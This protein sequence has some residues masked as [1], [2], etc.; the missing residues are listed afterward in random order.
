MGLRTRLPVARTGIALWLPTLVAVAGVLLTLALWQI[1]IAHRQAALTERFQI[2]AE[3][4]ANAIDRE[5]SANLSVVA[6]LAGVVGENDRLD[7]AAFLGVSRAALETRT[8]PIQ[9]LEWIPAVAH[10]DRAAFEQQMGF[11][12]RERNAGGELV[13]AAERDLYFP[14]SLVN[15]FV[16]NEAAVGFDLGSS[17]ARLESL[18]RARDTGEL[19][20][21]HPIRLVQGTGEQF[22]F[23]AVNPVFGSA[24]E[25]GI[26]E[27]RREHLLGFTLGVYHATDL[28]GGALSVFDTEE[29][30]IVLVD[31]NAPTTEQVFA[32]HPASL[33]LTTE[34]DLTVS[35]PEFRQEHVV[36]VGASQWTIVVQAA[37]AFRAL[38]AVDRW[39]VLVGGLI[40]TAL[41]V[42]LLRTTLVRA[43]Q[44]RE[45]VV[46]RTE[47]LRVQR[48]R[49]QS[50][51][52]NAQVGIFTT[53]PDN[54]TRTI[55]AAGLRLLD[56]PFE[57]LLEKTPLDL[58]APTHHH[59]MADRR[60]R[61]DAGETVEPMVEIPLLVGGDGDSRW[62]S[63]H[64]QPMF[65]ANRKFEGTQGIFSDISE[66]I[67]RREELAE[68]AS[69]DPLTELA[70]RRRFDDFLEEQVTIARRY[71]TPVSLVM[72]DLD[73]FKQLNDE[74]GHQ[75]GDEALRSVAVVLKWVARDADLVARYGGEEFTLVL[76][77]TDHEGAVAAGERCRA[78]IE[79]M[80]LDWWD[81]TIRITASVG[82]ATYD[83]NLH[84]SEADLLRDAD[85]AAYA[86][87]RAGRNAVRVA[88]D[89][90]PQH[91][92]S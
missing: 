13:P 35:A 48:D 21:T 51:F 70:N 14:V 89:L 65:D 2:V 66:E 20:V 90:A 57:L 61:R 33:M 64:L 47:E 24:A 17:P 25:V 87:K 86:A 6:M 32:A 85:G 41:V 59:L 81:Q 22:G 5:L 45:T 1:E 50:I 82:V 75:A 52:D 40:L 16:G 43:D 69:L 3:D 72:L 11:P 44:I 77:H 27:Q 15:P 67:A 88:N 79:A 56:R 29:V 58:V 18:E 12:I 39:S 9:A 74:Y 23:L 83:P 37:P 63:V 28:I 53:G 19:Q 36:Q 4:R 60:R 62:F 73:H 92:A 54:R 71:A 76:P 46:K 7:E 42:T 26:Q 49:Y 91:R 55:N 78:A 10:E 30:E 84:E 31:R 68:S 34:T 8:A 38:S 80:S